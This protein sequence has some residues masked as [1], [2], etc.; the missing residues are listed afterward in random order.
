MYVYIYAF[1]LKM[2]RT[3]FLLIPR[4]RYQFPNYKF[5]THSFTTRVASNCHR[6]SHLISDNTILQSSPVFEHDSPL[7]AATQEFRLLLAKTKVKKKTPIIFSGFR[8]I[9][10]LRRPNYGMHFFFFFLSG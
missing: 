4:F 5:I 9:T 1:E 2:L 3:F 8:R 7:T 10:Q 6:V